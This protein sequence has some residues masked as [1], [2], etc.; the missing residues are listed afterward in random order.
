M[1]IHPTAIVDPTAQIGDDVEIGPYCVIHSDTIVGDGCRLESHVVL[2]PYTHLGRGN[3][4]Y[5]GV[6]LGGE[7]QDKKW[8]GERSYLVLG[9]ANV[10][11]EG[12]TIHRATTPEGRTLIGD[13]NYFMAYSHIGHDA[14]VGDE[15]MIASYV[16]I[17]G[18]CIVEDL[19]TFGGIVGVHQYVRVG[20]MAMVG[21]QSKIVQDVPP[22][23]IADGRATDIRGINTVGLR[24]GGVS[25]ES[26]RA[27]KQ[28]YMLLWRSDL[29]TSN[30]IA[31]IRQEVEPTPE[32]VYLLD[33]LEKVEEGQMG[34]QLDQR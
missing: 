24:R 19:V 1:S 2:K 10:V 23:M 9:E 26:R 29:N 11:R 6:V 30:A 20:K 4:L 25:A 21:G 8:Q 12:A 34:R 31:R 3:H 22:F 14:T 18:F 13:R 7:P 28:A 33:F 16:G 17:S 5:P 32:V 15:T 27:L